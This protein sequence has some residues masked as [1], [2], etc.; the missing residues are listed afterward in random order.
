MTTAVGGG[1]MG[2]ALG[3]I[4]GDRFV[5]RGAA[6]AA[7][8]VQLR[9][10][11]AE[12]WLV[13]PGSAAEVAEIVRS[14]AA[15]GVAV[16]PVGNAARAPRT[17]LGDRPRLFVDLRRMNHVLHLDETSLVAHVQAGLSGLAL[18]RLLGP[19][20]LSVGDYPPAAL[21]STIGGLLAVR[22]P[23]KSSPR[24]GFLEDAVLGVSAVLADGRTVHTRV[25]PRRSTG[26]DLARAF[27]G[28]EGTLGIITSAVLRIHR[29][30]EARFLA[31]WALPGVG[32][33][34]AAMH[35]AMRE[36]AAPAAMR[37]YD[38]AEALVHVG[39]VCEPGEAVLAVA[40]AGPT[41]LAACDRDLVDSA[42][43]AIG[44]RRLAE[45]VALAWWKR[46]TGQVTEPAL[47]MPSL[48]VCASPSREAAV[49][50]AVCAAAGAAEA[51]A[52][53]H[54]ARFD[55]DGAV[56]YFTFTTADG[57]PLA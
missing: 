18:E 16:I 33:A 56:L 48:Q 28:S 22:T 9:G 54:I 23:G 5:E 30:P 34:V 52:R 46:R 14:A 50:D 45:E 47:P 21:G 8:G 29:R 36:D 20:G 11:D 43:S 4:V 15:A 25:A 1:G 12:A 40:T 31:A 39:P 13:K 2:S 24:H 3:A 32:H 7:L 44:G 41:D 19:R 57:A 26:P 6:L 53:A 27:L 35:L 49:Y 51:A 10:S 55:A 38:H 37:V 17:R 42:V